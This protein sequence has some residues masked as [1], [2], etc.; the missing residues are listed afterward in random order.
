MALGLREVA[1]IVAKDNRL[2][3]GGIIHPR[4]D[5]VLLFDGGEAMPFRWSMKSRNFVPFPVI[6]PAGFKAENLAASTTLIAVA[7]RGQI[8]A[9]P[10]LP[11][12]RWHQRS[13]KGSRLMS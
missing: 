8:A 1:R 6:L 9:A 4:V 3:A 7:G 11:T 2:F 12:I 13:C 5:E 10:T